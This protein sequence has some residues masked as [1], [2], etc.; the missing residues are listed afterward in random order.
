MK[1]DDIIQ[2]TGKFNLINGKEREREKGMGFLQQVWC[3]GKY[4]YQSHTQHAT[5]VFLLFFVDWKQ[6][7]NLFSTSSG[8]NDNLRRIR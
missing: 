6:L 5:N 2:T 7:Y 1:M 3:D 4:K 8:A